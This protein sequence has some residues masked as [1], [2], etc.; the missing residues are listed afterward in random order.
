MIRDDGDADDDDDEDD[1]L[2]ERREKFELESLKQTMTSREQLAD[3][4]KGTQVKRFG[5][6]AREQMQ[7]H[8]H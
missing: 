4:F 8:L 1:G 3:K 7:M 6:W 2:R 5:P